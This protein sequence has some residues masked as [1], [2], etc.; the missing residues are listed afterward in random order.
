MADGPVYCLESAR[1]TAKFVSHFKAI[2]FICCVGKFLVIIL[3][4]IILTK[5]KS[6]TYRCLIGIH[7]MN[8]DEYC[9]SD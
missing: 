1:G 4:Y 2:W 6:K 8:N 9:L 3:N 5:I 7:K